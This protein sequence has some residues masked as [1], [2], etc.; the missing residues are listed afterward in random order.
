MRRAPSSTLFRSGDTIMSR[1]V[2]WGGGEKPVDVVA[3]ADLP[4]GHGGRI[5][6]QPDLTVAEYPRVYALGDAAN[7]PRSDGVALPQLGSVDP[8]SRCEGPPP[9]R[10][11]DL[12]TRSCPGP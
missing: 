11:S 9:R 1:T 5:D 4:H 6:V 7:I 3:A 8:H 2:I 12:G 10:S